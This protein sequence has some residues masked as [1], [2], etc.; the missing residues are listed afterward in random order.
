MKV[1]VIGE[2][3]LDQFKIGKASRLCPEAPCPV[4]LPS[5]INQNDGLAANVVANLLSLNP[6][7]KI[8]FVHQKKIITKTRFVDDT[9]GYILLREDENDSIDQPLNDQDLEAIEYS[10][11]DGVVISD[12][13]KGFLSEE[14][15]NF[16]FSDCV[17][18][19][20]PT[21]MDTKK[22][23]GVWSK[24]CD[25]VKINQKEYDANVAK[26][27]CCPSK[28]CR[29][30]VA[31]KGGGGSSLFR[32]GNKIHHEFSK[33]IDVRDVSGA[34]DTYL[35]GF[36]SQYLS[37]AR[38]KNGIIEAMAFANA[39]ARVAVSKRGVVAVTRDEL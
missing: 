32:K 14:T 12:Y 21:F 3:G 5:Y 6:D 20:V 22:I 15:L 39:A 29:F 24:Q 30:L 28:H 38:T 13:H 4:F 7:W 25:Y 10:D 2:K 23:L 27:G 34:G 31:T 9:S 18:A 17:R 1:L 11:F 19:G 36:V 16:I 35:A 37:G 26:L 33:T 8:Q